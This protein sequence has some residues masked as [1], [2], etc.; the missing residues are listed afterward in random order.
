MGADP[1]AAMGARTRVAAKGQPS[2]EVPPYDIC[3]PNV[4]ADFANASASAL[5]VS[6]VLV[7]M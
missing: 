3:G 7:E 6:L 4:G 2:H 1:F 5:S